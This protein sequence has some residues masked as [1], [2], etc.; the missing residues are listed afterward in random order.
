MAEHPWDLCLLTFGATHRGGHQLWDRTN[1]AGEPDA[2]EAQALEEALREVYVACDRALGRVLEAA[3]P[4]VVVLVFSLHGMGPNTSRVDIL[5]ELL[6]RVLDGAA[7]A[8]PGQGG[9]AYQRGR[10]PLAWRH[11]LTRRL[12]RALQDRLMTFWRM[13][14]QD[15]S[16][17]AAFSLFADLHG[18]IRINRAGREAQGIVEP[19]APFDRLGRDIAQGLESFVDA[20]TGEPLVSVVARTDQVL[21]SGAQGD[22]LPD[23]VVRWSDTPAARHRALHSPRFGTI[24]WPTPGRNPDGR[25]GN[26]RFQGFF[27][28]RGPGF[29]E[30]ALLPEGDIVDLAPTILALLGLP[31]DPDGAREPLVEALQDRR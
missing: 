27:L 23:L 8:P 19:G 29:P 7:P 22:A 14:G 13:S 18:Y 25:S 21:P 28:A 11:A 1:L 16:R 31:P 15:W 26:H 4:E 3:G 24:D 17:T 12:P 6:A 5:P 2:A 10:V 9:L 30:G 20:D